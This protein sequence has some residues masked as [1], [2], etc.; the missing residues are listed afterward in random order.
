VIEGDFVGKDAKQSLT[1]L[2]SKYRQGNPIKFFTDIGFLSHIQNVL[3]E[4]FYIF[5]IAHFPNR[6]SY[7]MCLIEYKELVAAQD[8]GLESPTDQSEHALEDVKEEIMKVKE[9]VTRS[10]HALED[11]K[12]EVMKVKEFLKGKEPKF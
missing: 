10:E 2:R 9:F 6:H 4:E 11:V 5:N 8:K 7:K 12:E 3:V 1:L